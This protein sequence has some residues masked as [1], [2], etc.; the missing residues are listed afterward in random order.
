MVEQSEISLTAEQESRFAEGLHQFLEEMGGAHPIIYTWDLL[1][2]KAIPTY[3]TFRALHGDDKKTFIAYLFEL[4]IAD[5]L[6]TCKKA[7]ENINYTMQINATKENYRALAYFTLFKN[8]MR[9]KVDFLPEEVVTYLTKYFDLHATYERFFPL[10]EFPFGYTATQLERALKK[11]PLTSDLKL[12]IN[13]LLRHEAFESKRYYWGSDLQ[14]VATKLQKLVCQGD[15]ETPAQVPKYK[16]LSGDPF[17]EQVAAELAK[18][19]EADQPHWHGLF[20]EANAVS[21]GKPSKKY[22]SAANELIEKLG[23]AKFKSQIN[24]WLKLAT[25][26]P[27]R[28]EEHTNTYDNRTYRYTTREFLTDNNKNLLKGLVWTL[29]RFHDSAT[30]RGVANLAVRCFEK[31]P[32]IGPA[33]SGLGNA[34]VLVLA[35]TKGLEGIGHLSRLKLRIRQP[36]TQKLIQKHID[37][38]AKKLGLKPAQIEE[39]AAPGFDLDLGERIEAFDD[40]TLKLTL[41]AVGKVELGWHKPDGSPQKSVPAFV[42]TTK[43]HADRLKKLRAL[44]KDIEQSSRAQRDRI[45][46]LYVEDMSWAYEDFRK[47]YLDHGVISQ[48]ARNLI[49]RL[50]APGSETV[51]ALYVDDGWQAVAGDAFEPAAETIVRMWHPIEVDADEVLAWRD[52]LDTL[53]VTQPMKQAYREVYI[54]T[55]AELNTRLYSNRMAAHLLKQHQFNALA[56]LRGWKYALLGAFDDGRDN[57]LAEKHLPAYGIKA[58]YWIDEIHDDVDRTNE[59]GIWDYVATDQ[60]RFL[61]AGSHPMEMIDVP[62]IVF[63][64]IMRDVDLFVGV[65]SVGND[66]QWQDSGTTREQRDYWHS[67]SFGDLSELAKTRKAV[68]ERLLPRLKIRDK[69]HIDGKFLIVDGKRHSYKIHIGSTNIL[70]QPNDRYLCI[71][72]G[73]GKDKTTDNIHL[74]F[75]GDRGL[76]IVLSKAFMLADD[77]KIT[78]PTILSQL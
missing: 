8:L 52:R 64:E 62:R 73:R 18:L 11:H 50:T 13:E 27:V 54:V 28:S 57:A 19:P 76:S 6:K 74:P 14:K 41:K 16:R 67:Y 23:A 69:A 1:S 17:G 4:A 42:K 35:Q 40:F 59:T 72:P 32:G 70:I 15:G 60:L 77:N 30:L 7:G 2:L 38:Q 68:L 31:I 75:E 45:D 71:V 29:L 48:I 3:A 37:E 24:Q 36:S 66:P 53:S 43:K 51:S 65:A 25:S 34:C 78:D 10:V 58:E 22:L 5:H 21:G 49:W 26:V 46:R 44:V 9:S 55:D 20:H 33:A 39:L 56:G 61:N 47:Y 12:Q 63:S